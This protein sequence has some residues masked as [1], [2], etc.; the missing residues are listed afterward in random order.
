VTGIN[1]DGPKGPETRAV[2]MVS[3]GTRKRDEFEWGWCPE[4]F[5]GALRRTIK[6][7]Q[8]II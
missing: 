7:L 5:L 2:G 4:N 1:T 6:V 3:I 8:S